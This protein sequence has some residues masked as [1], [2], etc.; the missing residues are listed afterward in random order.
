MIPADLATPNRVSARFRMSSGLTFEPTLVLAVESDKSDDGID[1]FTSSTS[2]L[3]LGVLVRYPLRS[4]GRVDLS[5]IGSAGI[6]IVST[7]P[8]GDDN[9][10]TTSGVTV[11][12]GLA[13]DYWLTSHWDISLTAGNPVFTTI[14]ETRELGAGMTTEQSSTTFGAIFDP[15]LAVMLHLYL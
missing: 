15:T 12:W 10:R 5:L 1:S 6:A 11:G 14:S 3:E 2:D 8:D 13:L 9:D 7:D 4:R